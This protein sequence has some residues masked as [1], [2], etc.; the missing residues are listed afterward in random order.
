M[1]YESRIYIV[2]KFDDVMI[3]DDGKCF[4][5]IISMFNMCKIPTLSNVLRY[6]PVTNC[7]IY[8]DDGSTRILEDCYGEPLKESTIKSVI[9]ALEKAIENGECYWRI[10]PLLST[11]QTIEECGLGNSSIVVLHYGY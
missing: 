10:Y 7:Y 6:K 11:L 1:G 4:A 5:Q 2:E 8:A 3:Y 9:D